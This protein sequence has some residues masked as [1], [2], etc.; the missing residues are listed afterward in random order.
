MTTGEN[1]YYGGLVRYD[2]TPKPAY[3]L[4]KKLFHETWHTQAQI[5]SDEDGNASFKGFYGDYD[6]VATLPDGSTESQALHLAK[7]SH[8]RFSFVF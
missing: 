1:A 3:N 8:N 4:V 6:A 2:F 7:S 5:F